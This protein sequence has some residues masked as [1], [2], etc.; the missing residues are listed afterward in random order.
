MP[1]ETPPDR[2][3]QLF[4]TL[5]RAIARW[6]WP[7]LVACLV[8]AAL[9]GWTGMGVEK[10][11]YGSTVEIDGTPSKRVADALR[12]HFAA[13]MA[14]LAVVAVHADHLTWDQVAF[15]AA[16]D[17]AASRLRACRQ[18]AKVLTPREA[19]DPRLHSTDGHTALLVVSLAAPSAQDAERDTPIVRDAVAPALERLRSADGSVHWATT[20][21]GALAFDVAQYGVKDG[22]RAEAAVLPLTLTILLVAFGALVAAGMPLLMGM[23]ATSATL[24]LVAVV[25][26]VYPLSIAVQNVATMLGL[27]VGIDYSLI[28]IGRFR[29]AQ[30][31]G[32]G[33]VDA[34]AEAMRTAGLA[35]ACSGCTVMIGLAALATT[36][37]LNTRSIG[38]GGAL[39]LLVGVGLSLTLLPAALAILGPRVDSPAF[40]RR[41]LQRLSPAR[42]WDA[43]AA[44]VCGHAGPLA[45]AGTLLMALLCA[46]VLT[47]HTDFADHDLLPHYDLEFQRGLDMLAAMGRR[48]AGAPVQ[49]LVAADHG[50]VLE[51]HALDG[52]L[53][54]SRRLHADPRVTE[55]LGPVDWRPGLDEAGYRKLYHH[56]RALQALAPDR[57]GAIVSKDGTEALVQVVPRDD[58][59]FEQIQV[60]AR[61]LGRAPAPPGVSILVG[62]QAA[63]YNDVHYALLASVPWLVAFVVASTFLVLAQ[64]FRSWLVP[65]K[66][67]VLN[68]ASVG[69]GCG[70][71]TVVFQWGW[72]IHWLGLEHPVGGVPPSILATIFCIVFGLSMDYE[73]FLISRIAEDFQATRDNAR[74][75][76]DGLAATGGI[77]T[78]AALI[79]VTVFAGFAGVRLVLVQMLGVG[80]ATA[81]LVDATVVRVLL[82]PAFMTLAGD[83]NW[84]PGYKK[85]SDRKEEGPPS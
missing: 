36:P 9:G 43:W 34:V 70:V 27:A 11:L 10:L 82:A 29:E 30:A 60:L 52:L 56:W 40:L 41:R 33:T 37:S 71:L 55:V 47:L 7:V 23:L 83:W 5:A 67:T 21:A 3:S 81:V 84:H 17:D 76:R 22:Q 24:G 51:G 4:D 73:V 6:R 1:V 18:V 63:L 44:W 25:A 69:A 72:G 65:L 13:P 68:L 49:L 39:V 50:P 20:G 16:L 58:Q 14:S 79:M 54:L 62:G 38:V 53:A 57:F 2:P 80:L 77:I 42:H 64:A 46:P 31:R 19:H 78:A 48:N 35:V 61:D 75:V 28:V 32:I 15:A 74:A 85:L 12:T 45:I 26:K 8:L 59:R 66:A